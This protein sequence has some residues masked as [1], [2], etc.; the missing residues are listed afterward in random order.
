M[1]GQRVNESKSSFFISTGAMEEQESLVTTILGF[2]EAGVSIYVFGS[3]D[4]ERAVA[5]RFV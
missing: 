1:V 4:L 2:P 5:V 3:P